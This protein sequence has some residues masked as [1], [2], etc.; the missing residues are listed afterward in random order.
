[1][2][3]EYKTVPAPM[4]LSI[5][6]Q[7]EAEGAIR[8]FGELISSEA[9]DGWEFHSMETITTSEAPGCTSGGKS[10]DTHYNMLVFK[11]QKVA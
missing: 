6:N 3:F 8:Q 4:A 2:H 10:K 1:M 11:R 7:K 5:K 9:K